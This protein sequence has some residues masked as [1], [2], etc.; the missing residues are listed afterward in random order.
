MGS[1]FGKRH[2]YATDGPP[3]NRIRFRGALAG[4]TIW[5]NNSGMFLTINK[6]SPTSVA[7]AQFSTQR[8]M[9]CCLL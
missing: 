2:C 3:D 9:M 8:A 1:A 4:F 6:N 7:F 5:T